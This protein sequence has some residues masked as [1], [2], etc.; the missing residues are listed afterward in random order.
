MERAA[1]D[2]EIDLHGHLKDEA[3]H[4]LRHFLARSRSSG[5]RKVR[6]I[7][8][9]GLH[10]GDGKGVLK[11][12]ARAVLAKNPNV[13]AWGEAGRTEGGSGATWVWLK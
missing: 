9:K 13:A 4:L 2:D 3:V 12:A 1:T 8:G 5:A 11:E 6:I 10:S 7:H